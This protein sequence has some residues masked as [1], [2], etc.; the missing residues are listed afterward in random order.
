MILLLQEVH[1]KKEGLIQDKILLKILTL[2]NVNSLKSQQK[3]LLKEIEVLISLLQLGEQEEDIKDLTIHLRDQVSNMNINTKDLLRNTSIMKTK[4]RIEEIVTIIREE[5][6][7]ITINLINTKE[8]KKETIDLIAETQ[9][10]DT[11]D[12]ILQIKRE[13]RDSNTTI[14]TATTLIDTKEVTQVATTTTVL[15]ITELNKFN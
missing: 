11:K 8:K 3:V 4:D 13:I 1:L 14:K 5:V 15:L 9:E 12:I 7:T 2:I 10:K 6:P